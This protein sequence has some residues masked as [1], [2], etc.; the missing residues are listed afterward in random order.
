RAARELPAHDVEHYLAFC[1][2][3]RDRALAWARREP[4]T[5]PPSV[6]VSV[7]AA[8]E[9]FR[10]AGGGA[11]LARCDPVTREVA[12]WVHGALGD[13]GACAAE[14]AAA[15]VL[16]EPSEPWMRAAAGVDAAWSWYGRPLDRWLARLVSAQRVLAVAELAGADADETVS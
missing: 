12:A 9:S 14:S 4:A 7:H 6:R 10:L 11:S 16:G 13:G 8:A 1:A 15:Q 5:D 3:A 2:A